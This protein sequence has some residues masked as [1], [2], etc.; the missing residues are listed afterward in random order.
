VRDFSLGIGIVKV[1]LSVLPFPLGLL[2]L[3]FGGVEKRRENFPFLNKE[4][5]VM[6][7]KIIKM[8]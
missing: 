4:S 8:I 3:G 6:F 5:F 1:T 7:I 2:Q